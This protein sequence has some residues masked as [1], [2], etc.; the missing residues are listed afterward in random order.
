MKFLCTNFSSKT[1]TEEAGVERESCVRLQREVG[2]E[3]AQTRGTLYE[4]A[5]TGS[6]FCSSFPERI[7][8]SFCCCLKIRRD[9]KSNGHH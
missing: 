3:S 9:H 4:R 5:V 1:E 7:D 6:V 8:R 2:E